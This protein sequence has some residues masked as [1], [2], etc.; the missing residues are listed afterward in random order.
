MPLLVKLGF[1]ANGNLQSCRRCKKKSEWNSQGVF[2]WLDASEFTGC[3][4]FVAKTVYIIG[5][6]IAN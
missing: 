6:G 5:I 4:G 1:Y 3:W 2:P